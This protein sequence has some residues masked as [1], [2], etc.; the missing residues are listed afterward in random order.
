[1]NSH[2]ARWIG[3]FA[4]ACFLWVPMALAQG[5]AKAHVEIPTIAAR[6][7]DVS[8]PEAIVKAD[9]ESISGGVG[10]PRQWARD[11]SLYDPNARSFS[12]YTD[13][14]TS[15]LTIW[16]PTLQEYADEADAH[17]VSEGFV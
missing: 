1:M 2:L 7:E 15:T 5:K 6:P 14:K 17:F 11:L 13:S 16:A 3:I 8:S 10:V 9:Y 4:F 12:V